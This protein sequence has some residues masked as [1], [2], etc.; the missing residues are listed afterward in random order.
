MSI[1]RGLGAFTRSA[2][3][4][5]PLVLGVLLSAALIHCLPP[6]WFDVSAAWAARAPFWLQGMAMAAI[7]LLIQT[8]AGRG[9]APFVYGNF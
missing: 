3:N 1:L 4:L 2:E 5:T 8:L 7:V 9:S 6:R